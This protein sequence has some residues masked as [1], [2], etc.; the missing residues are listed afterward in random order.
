MELELEPDGS[1]ALA[2]MGSRL[3]AT[4]V[5]LALCV[6][7]STILMKVAFASIVNSMSKVHAQL[8]GV[9]V[10]AV[11][12]GVYEIGMVAVRARTLGNEVTKTAVVH[13][14]DLSP[15]TA[16]QAALRFILGPLVFCGGAAVIWLQPMWV[17]AVVAYVVA[18]FTF[19]IMSAS[20]QT[21]HDKAARTVVVL[22]S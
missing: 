7:T 9:V 2:S 15:A 13:Q 6:M 17:L 5:D 22:V 1:V 11:L 20:G 8:F 14:D 18:D 12:L 3:R 21:L 19:G 4:L 16:I 10:F